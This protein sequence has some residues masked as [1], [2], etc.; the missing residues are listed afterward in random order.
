[1][2][3]AKLKESFQKYRDFLS[4]PN[5]AD[6]LYLWEIQQHFQ[7]NWDLKAEDLPA[8]YDRSLQSNHTRRHWRRE[9]YEPKQMMLGFM[10]LDSEYLRQV[11]KDLFNENNEISGRVDR[12]VFHCDQ[13]LQEYKR[14][15]PRSIDNNHYHDDGYQMISFYLAMRHPAAY[16]L[17]EGKK[18]VALLEVLGTRNLPR[19]DDFE[20]F[21]KI[22]RTIYK[23][24][25]KEE[26]LL[27]LHR[28]RLNPEVHY[29]E[30]SL[31]V[32]Y[33]FYQFISSPR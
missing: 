32:V 24:M 9:N 25:Q 4:G 21:C 14:K 13:L 27:D 3:V 15:H 8:M 22:S 12:F 31:L 20:R 11:F 7:H 23:L 5:A 1:M 16:T 17:Y 29:S 10:G 19:F 18:F 33:D 2:Q 6:R 28:A 30:E 26:D